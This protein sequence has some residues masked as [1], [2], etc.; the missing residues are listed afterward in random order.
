MFISEP[1]MEYVN[2]LPSASEAE[3]LPMVVWFSAALKVADELMV[4]ALLLIG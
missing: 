4:G 3:T 1:E 2:E